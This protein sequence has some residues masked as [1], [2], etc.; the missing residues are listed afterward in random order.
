[1]SYFCNIQVCEQ[2]QIMSISLESGQG[3]AGDFLVVPSTKAL[4]ALSGHI[5][6]ALAL[7]LL[8]LVMSYSTTAFAITAD[9][10]FADANRLFR[11]DLYWAA[12]LRYRQASDA[13]MDSPL[14]HYNTGV[15]HYK[16]Q[17]H[18]RA[19]Q[20]LL[21]ASRSRRLEILSH[22]NLALNA[23]KSGNTDKALSWFRKA[24]DQERN[25]RIRALAM[26]AIRRIRSENQQPR[27]SVLVAQKQQ[28][29]QDL[30]RFELRA[31]VGA[32]IDSNVFRSPSEPYVDLSNPNNPLIVP[33]VQEGFFIPVNLSAKYSVHSFE[34]ES[35]F[36]AYR[37]GGRFYQDAALTNGNEYLHQLSFG[38]EYE[39]REEGR[40]QRIYSAFTVAQHEEVFFDRD[41]GAGRA[42]NAID[43]ENRFN[44]LRFGPEFLFR[45]SYNRLAIGA[46]GKAQIWNYD[47]TKE[48]PEYDHE[49]FLLGLNAQYRFRGI[50]LLRVTVDVSKRK[51][52]DRPSFELDG[53]QPLGNRP[54]EYNRIELGISVRQ[55]VTRSLWFSLDYIRTDRDD[56]HVGYNNYVRDSYG[57]ELH[58]RI[59]N[60][61]DFE[62]SAIYQI[63]DYEN[64]FAFQNPAAGRKQ[65]ERGLGKAVAQFYL[66]PHLTLLAEYRYEDVRSNDARIAYDRSRFGLSLRWDN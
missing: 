64:A 50:S 60:R 14:L 44:Y 21:K 30:F 42:V 29:K 52:G 38:S 20:S 8:V 47:D 54:V 10:L 39:R 23:W 65:L 12:L 62:A 63:Y 19:R 24:R 59:G 66:N 22:Y 5:S 4:T 57:T 7:V 13:G 46:R 51:F 18:I 48:V 15:A 3:A 37:F 31:R 40:I 32:G 26:E 2:R 6:K 28:R 41:T 43:I 9:E 55:R 61:F 35:F 11:D 27:R 45:Q 56:L 34:R 16:A 25:P 1:M 49:Y 17:Q 33:D 58:W 53:T 36:G